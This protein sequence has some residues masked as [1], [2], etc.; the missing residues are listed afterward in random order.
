MDLLKFCSSCGQEKPLSSF[1]KRLDRPVGVQ[2]NCK[3]CHK[4]LS[5]EW[6]KKNKEKVNKAALKWQQENP[7]K[8]DAAVK[9][10]RVKNPLKVKQY[11]EN[12]RKK[13]KPTLKTRLSKSISC[14]MRKSLRK[15]KEG[16]HW[17]NL[18]GFTVDQLK[19]HLE[20]MFTPEMSWDNYGTYWEIDHKIPIAVFN[21]ERPQHIDFHLCWELR[22]LQPLERKTNSSK[23]AKLTK[24]FQPSLKLVLV[25]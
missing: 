15:S 13:T 11:A 5:A 9:K 20:K 2:S 10:W 1:A 7:S 3:A 23:G 25:K 18:V 14:G 21:F 4:K 6:Y 22:N 17:E 16:L 19:R 12:H 8:K 24:P